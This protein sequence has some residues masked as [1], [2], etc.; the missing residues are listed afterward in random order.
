MYKETQATAPLRNLD[1]KQR[2]RIVAEEKAGGATYTPPNLADFVAQRIVESADLP[3]EKTHI[4]DPAIGDGELLLSLLAHLA[5]R[6]TAKLAIY[7][8]ETNRLALAEAERRIHGLFPRALLHLRHGNFLEFALEQA[9][10]LQTPLPFAA[11]TTPRAFD[12]IIANPPYVRTQIMGSQRAQILARAFELKGR[13]DLYHAFLIG[14][15]Q[16]L[17]PT[18]TA[19]IIVSNRFMTT[20]AGAGLRAALRARFSLQHI[21]DLGDTKL[22]DAAVLPAVIL[23]K[24]RN[25]KDAGSPAFSSIYET[26]DAANC[27]APDP[28]AALSTAGVTAVKDGR[29][30]RVN[31]GVLDGTGP[32]N[33]VWRIATNASDAWLAKVAQRTSLTFGD[34][35]KIR[36]GVKTCADQVFIR[37]DWHAMPH[38]QR[39]ELLRS[40]TTHHIAARF[41]TIPAE[42]MHKILYPHENMAGLRQAMNLSRYPKSRVYLEAHRETLERRTYVLEAGRKWYEIWVP[43]DPAAWELPKLVFR[44][45]SERPAF[46]LDLEGTIVNGDCYWLAARRREHD[47]LLWLA[48]AVANSTFVEAFYDR[49]FNNKLYARRRRFITQYVEL[50]PLPDPTTQLARNIVA[51]AKAIYADPGSPE[52]AVMEIKLDQLVWQAFG[53]GSEC[54]DSRS[55]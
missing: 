31:H 6:T 3:T 37:S 12:L 28:I 38:S 30:F 40:L 20:K 24:G 27:A 21:W 2:Y 43:Q 33:D 5:P 17:K 42:N 26:D 36:V 7:G 10:D 29:R 1:S 14:M 44:D 51:I 48:A 15:A 35:G 39:P 47:E 41:H 8:F 4:L 13:V 11:P 9:A 54:C 53:L 32:A 49:R 45:I 23:A 46:W 22:F 16:V 34:I 52:A 55:Y 19:G 25:G 18:G 50:F